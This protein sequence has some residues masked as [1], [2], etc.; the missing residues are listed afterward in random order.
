MD[1]RLIADI[2]NAEGCNLRAYKDTLGYWTIG[3]GHKLTIVAI[4]LPS[5]FQEITQAQADEFLAGDLAIAQGRA[6]ALPEWKFLDTS[7]R[8]NAVIELEFNMAG[9]WKLFAETRLDIQNQ[10][11][12]K[13]HDDLLNS[14]WAKQVG[15]TRSNRLANY[16]LEGTYV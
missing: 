11:W 12:Q 4:N 16:L 14:L 7:C 13:A 3:Y 6:Q 2:K 15:Q 1:P 8:Q 10:N 5:Q 9:K